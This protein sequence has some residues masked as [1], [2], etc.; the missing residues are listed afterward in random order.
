MRVAGGVERGLDRSVARWQ[1]HESRGFARK[2]SEKMHWKP[3]AKKLRTRNKQWKQCRGK[4]RHNRLQQWQ[5][6]SKPCFSSSSSSSK[7]SKCSKHANSKSASGDS[8][9]NSHSSTCSSHSS[10]TRSSNRH[11]NQMPNISIASTRQTAFKCSNHTIMAVLE[12]VLLPPMQTLLLLQLR[13]LQQ[14]LLLKVGSF[15]ELHHRLVWRHHM[16]RP[17]TLRCRAALRGINIHKRSS[18]SSSNQRCTLSSQPTSHQWRRSSW[19]LPCLLAL[20]SRS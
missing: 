11:N 18:S 20:S 2:K 13:Q 17:V 14:Q 6:R 16:S 9:N 3:R 15:Q 8:R 7:C 10:T 19:V 1:P 5:Q 4:C 12:A